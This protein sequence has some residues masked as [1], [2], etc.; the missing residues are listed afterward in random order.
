MR[1]KYRDLIDNRVEKIFNFKKKLNVKVIIEKNF[2]E[3]K[4]INFNNDRYLKF[5]KCVIASINITIF[6][7]Y[8]SSR[9]NTFVITDF[10]FDKLK[11]K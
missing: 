7:T 9:C 8:K 4:Y 2:K 1:K 10:I 11:N 5:I 6:K 3:I